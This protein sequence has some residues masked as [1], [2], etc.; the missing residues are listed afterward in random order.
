M[1]FI[2]VSPTAD[3]TEA[4]LKYAVIV[5]HHTLKKNYKD[6]LHHHLFEQ[7]DTRLDNEK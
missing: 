4:T 6:P 2:F 5:G 1:I 7:F 3:K